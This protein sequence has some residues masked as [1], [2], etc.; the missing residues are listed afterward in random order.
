MLLLKSYKVAGAYQPTLRRVGFVPRPVDPLHKAHYVFMQAQIPIGRRILPG[1]FARATL[2]Q[3]A[4]RKVKVK[5]I[6]VTSCQP[7]STISRALQ[8][9]GRRNVFPLLLQG[10]KGSP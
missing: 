10:S 8:G 6:T 2:Y 5:Y 3:P 7:H 4:H 1:P 9:I